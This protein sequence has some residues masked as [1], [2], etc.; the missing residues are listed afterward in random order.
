MAEQN[1]GRYFPP[2]E[3]RA[4][5]AVAVLPRCR[6]GAEKSYFVCQTTWG[7]GPTTL[8]DYSSRLNFGRRESRTS[9]RFAPGPG[10]EWSL[11]H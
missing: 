6:D 1:S 2:E 3:E 8:I 9:R 11:C 4:Q 5:P 10:T 7:H